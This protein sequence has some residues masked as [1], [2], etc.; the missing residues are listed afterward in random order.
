MTI[1][2]DLKDGFEEKIPG[3]IHPA[4]KTARPQMLKRKDN[5]QYYSLIEKFG[6]ISGVEC[7]LNTSF[8]LH[9]DPIVETPKQALE[10]F[11]QTEIDILLFDDFAVCQ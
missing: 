1:A 5:P 3:A 2:F 4:D 11:E 8:N 7:I 9:G 6:E 10:T